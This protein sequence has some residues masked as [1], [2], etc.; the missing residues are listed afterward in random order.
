MTERSRAGRLARKRRQLASVSQMK[1]ATAL[2]NSQSVGTMNR[3]VSRNAPPQPD[4]VV[5]C[6][7]MFSCAF[8]PGVIR[9]T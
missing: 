3:Y 7:S 4:Q 9:A 2:G 5:N 6:S 8:V 1:N